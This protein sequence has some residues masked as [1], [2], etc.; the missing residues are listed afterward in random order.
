MTGSIQRKGKVYYIVFR[1]FDSE[2]G[3]RKLKWIPAGNS[4]RAAERQLNDLMG[5]VHN[6]TFR[7]LKKATFH[8]F[9]TLWLESYAKLKTK[10]STFRSYHDIIHKRLIPVMGDYLLTEITTAKLQRYV[11]LR[12]AEV[13]PKTVINEIVPIKEMFRHA[14]RWGYLRVNPA[15]YLERP[16]TY[17]KE[18][19]VLTLNEVAKFLQIDHYY[20]TAFLTCV[21]TGLRAGEL[22][23]LQWTDI[24]WN[25]GQ[26]FV[27]RALWT[28]QFQTPKSKYSIRKIDLLPQ[29]INELKHWKTICPENEHN[30]V[31]PSVEGK[32]SIHENVIK[33]YFN[34][35]LKKAGVRRVSFH[36]LR[37]T[38]ASIRIEAGQNIKYIQLQM[39][40]ASIQTTLDRYGHM[41]RE[42]NT[43]QI[44]R[45]E[46]VL[47]FVEKSDSFSDT[48]NESVR[49]LLEDFGKNKSEGILNPLPHKDLEAVVNA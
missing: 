39:G 1:I 30:L 21:L 48:K 5:D 47:G 8:E 27:K 42:V 18:I 24:N 32:M 33:R 6:G 31:F 46:N 12:L 37:H 20:R 34:P 22:W 17:R 16:R 36:S 35:A 28:D 41:I 7:E 11:A 44:R 23:G 13:K 40:H 19:E 3:K 29:L 9:A 10:P 25:L 14:V 49:R 26:V 15:E 2:S 4:K 45:L 38:N 43:E